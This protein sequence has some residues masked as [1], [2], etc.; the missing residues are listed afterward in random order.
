MLC[1][2]MINVEQV[3]SQLSTSFSSALLRILFFTYLHW[4]YFKKNNWMKQH[5]FEPFL[6]FVLYLRHWTM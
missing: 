4:L 6:G 3:E 5:F 1:Y 2:R